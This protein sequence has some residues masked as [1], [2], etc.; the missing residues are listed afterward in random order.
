MIIRGWL[1]AMFSVLGSISEL[2]V[3][4]SVVV[5]GGPVV[6]CGL[7]GD[8]VR[9]GLFLARRALRRAALVVRGLLT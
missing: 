3:M 8:R 1:G 7:L 6:L 2:P 4:Q 5:E 9:L